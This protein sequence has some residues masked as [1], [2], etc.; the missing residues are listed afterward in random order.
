MENKLHKW[1][2]RDRQEKVK[3]ADIENGCCGFGDVVF[4]N[5]WIDCEQFVRGLYFLAYGFA[6]WNVVVDVDF[7][8]CDLALGSEKRK[9][10]EG[11]ESRP[12]FSFF[13]CFFT[14]WKTLS[15]AGRFPCTCTCFYPRRAFS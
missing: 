15:D 1:K 2:S 3:H 10:K 12:S 4:R 8:S 7:I 13:F 11:G 9:L 14:G 6:G 5:K